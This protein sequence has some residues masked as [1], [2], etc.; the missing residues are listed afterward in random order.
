MRKYTFYL[1]ENRTYK[2]EIDA[3]SEMKARGILQN[4]SVSQVTK[5][6]YDA[7]DLEEVGT[8]KGDFFEKPKPKK[9]TKK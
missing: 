7:T 8:T 2:V 9:K 3:E 4:M 1:E 5:K 6:L